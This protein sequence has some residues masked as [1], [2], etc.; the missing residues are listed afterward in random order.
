MPSL[1]LLANPAS[2]SLTAKWTQKTRILGDTFSPMNG[3]I[4][5]IPSH[6]KD[7]V[8]ICQ[9]LMR[10]SPKI[11]VWK[12]KMHYPSD[13]KP[14]L[15]PVP[16]C[17]SPLR[18]NRRRGPWQLAPFQLCFVLM[19]DEVILPLQW[20][21]MDKSKWNYGCACMHACVLSHFSCVWLCTPID[22]SPQALLSMGFS[23]QEYWGGLPFPLPGDL[24]DPGIELVSLTPT[25]LAGGVFFFTTS[26]KWVKRSFVSLNG[27]KRSLIFL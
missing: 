11:N 14:T 25:A 10:V 22:C 16:L 21:T 4:F 2:C 13:L 26:A 6:Q 5:P 23:R 20:L 18:R 8:Q 9:Y 3:E 1:S 17:D 15:F 12:V 27:A 7:H 19:Y 24:P